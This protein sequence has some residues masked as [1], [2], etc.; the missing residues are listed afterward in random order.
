MA[1]VQGVADDKVSHGTSITYGYSTTASCASP[2]ANLGNLTYTYDNDS[3]IVGMGG[4]LAAV[5][6]P[7]ATTQNATYDTRNQLSTWNGVSAGVNGSDDINSDPSNGAA[8]TWDERNRRN[9]MNMVS[10]SQQR[11]R[12]SVRSGCLNSGHCLATVRP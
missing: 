7:P 2:P 4:S 10:V 6:L 9:Q 8:Y 5:V 1:A 11:W 12:I 3:R